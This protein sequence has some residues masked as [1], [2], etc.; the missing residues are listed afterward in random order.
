MKVIVNSFQKSEICVAGIGKRSQL[1]GRCCDVRLEQRPGQVGSRQRETP[2][3]DWRGASDGCHCQVLTTR[4]TTIYYIEICVVLKDAGGVRC[5][6]ETEGGA[7]ATVRARAA[8]HARA[9]RAAG[10]LPAPAPR[11]PTAPPFSP[12]YPPTAA[13]PDPR[14]RRPDRGQGTSLEYCGPNIP[15]R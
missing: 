1:V 14:P 9:G 10:S 8:T 13:Q 2:R 6:G 7:G 12:S 3:P 15:Q 11:L 4:P 5:P